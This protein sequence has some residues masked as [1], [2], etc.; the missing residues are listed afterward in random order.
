MYKRRKR[1]T[2]VGFYLH[3]APGAV[4]FGDRSGVVGARGGGKPGE[5]SQCVMGTECQFGE[6]G[7]SSAGWW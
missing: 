2:A 7:R 1:R 3:R 5:G 4:R 6:M